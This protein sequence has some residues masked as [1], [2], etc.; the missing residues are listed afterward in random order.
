M[1]EPAVDVMIVGAGPTGLAL[2]IQLG[3]YGV[4]CRIVD[5]APALYLIRPDVY[6]GFRSQPADGDALRAYL[7]RIFIPVTC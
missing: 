2:A 5:S 3:R 4:S 6:I 7:R 1:N